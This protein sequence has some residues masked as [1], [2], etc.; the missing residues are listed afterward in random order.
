MYGYTTFCLVLDEPYGVVKI[1]SHNL[2][3][4]QG[5]AFLAKEWSVDL[6]LCLAD[7]STPEVAR[8]VQHLQRLWVQHFLL[9][10]PESDHLIDA[11]EEE[12]YAT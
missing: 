5:L 9:F 6:V 12:H 1:V 8:L 10:L 4:L 2:A 7:S 11:E 3:V